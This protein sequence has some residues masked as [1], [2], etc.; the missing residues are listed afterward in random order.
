MVKESMIDLMNEVIAE[1]I[2]A[3]QEVVKEDIVPLIE[4]RTKLER[5]IFDK[6]FKELTELE[7]EEV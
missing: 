2:A 6:A 3:M 4:F 1:D 7:E 5:E